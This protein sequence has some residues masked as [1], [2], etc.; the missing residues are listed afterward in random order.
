VAIDLQTV[1]PQSSIPINRTKMVVIGGIRALQIEGT[2]FRSVDSVFVND[3]ESPDVVVVS[4]TQLLAQLPDNLQAVPD[5]QS[6]MVLSRSLTLTASSVLRFRIGNVPSA[7]SGIL[8][9]MQLFVK[10]LISEPGSDIF[11]KSL[12]GGLLRSMGSTF[13]ADDGDSIRTNAVIAV[14]AVAKQIVALQSRDGTL[15][16]DERLMRASVLNAVFS[17]QSTSL[18]LSVELLNQTGVPAQLNLEL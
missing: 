6:V 9:M 7:V 14:D 12:G 4:P 16:R 13:G 11:N 15:P 5:V 8:R 17:R 1:F 18:F 3:T 10:L 2:D